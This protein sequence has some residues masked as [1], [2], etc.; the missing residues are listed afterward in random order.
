MEYSRPELYVNAA[1]L[2]PVLYYKHISIY[3]DEYVTKL[4][5]SAKKKKM[6]TK[7]TTTP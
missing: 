2:T 1:L 6:V 3:L 7:T 5:F 4:W